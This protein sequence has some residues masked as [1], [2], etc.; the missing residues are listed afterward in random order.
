MN[1]EKFA[2]ANNPINMTQNAEQNG[3]YPA[4]F[5][6]GLLATVLLVAAFFTLTT[7]TDNVES[8]RLSAGE[9]LTGESAVTYLSQAGSFDSLK[10]AF[11]SARYNAVTTDE[12]VRATNPA[13]NLRIS[14]SNRGLGLTSSLEN[15]NWKSGWRLRSL[16]YGKNQSEAGQGELSAVGNKVELIRRQQ[17]VTEWYLNSPIGVEHGFTLAAKPDGATAGEPLRLVMELDGDLMAR[18]DQNGLALTLL[19]DVGDETLRYEKLKVWDATGN[20]L[21]A[22]MQSAGKSVWFDVDDQTAV[23]PVT[24]DPTF[25]QPQKVVA[26]DG[27]AGDEFGGAVAI[28]GDTAVVGASANDASGSGLGSAYIFVRS[29]STWVFQQKLTANDAAPFDAFGSFV[30]IDGNTAVVGSFDDSTAAVTGH[31]SAYVFVRSGTTWTQQQKLV[32][33]DA[34]SFDAF[35]RSVAIA[36][37]TIAVGAPSKNIGINTDQGAAYIFVRSGST[38]TQ[39]QRLTA[40]DGVGLDYF[41]DSIALSGQTVIIGATEDTTGSNTQQGSA[42]VFV[43]SGT[44]WTQQ[45]KLTASDGAIFDFFGFSVAISGDSAIIGTLQNVGANF[46]QGSAYVFVRSGTTWSQQQ[47]LLASDGATGDSFGNSVAIFSDTAVVGAAGDTFGSNSRQ[48]SAYVFLRSGTAW[49]QQPK[50]SAAGGAADDSFGASVAVSID[51]VIAGAL[52]AKIGSNVHQGAAYFYTA[53]LTVG[54]RVVT[55]SGLG[56]RN[57]IVT[58]TDSQGAR[59]TATT[60]S[61][62]F[63]SFDNVLPGDTY[64]IGVSSKRYRFAAKTLLI[65]T[66]LSNVDFTGLE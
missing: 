34:A 60:S 40:S 16:G 25:I 19:N 12:G 28:S 9:R 38:W 57:A 42:Y 10:T 4:F 45:Q 48:G 63:Y 22:R 53:G 66:D 43:R 32:A 21:T 18:A 24:I 14:F 51:T 39:Q 13:N 47:K 46:Q 6:S 41:G 50:L 15:A 64:I 62:G 5:V 17:G 20:L 61:F 29:G 55:P 33:N 3:H 11:R 1:F 30:A 56:L 52:G 35:G 23:Y 49:T 59:R 27:A 8:Q 37:D 65:T 2:I 58:M 44:T 54:G 26:P 7:H 31:G 36:G